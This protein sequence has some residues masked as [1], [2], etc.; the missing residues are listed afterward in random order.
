MEKSSVNL[1]Q[2]I[3]EILIWWLQLESKGESVTAKNLIRKIL[4]KLWTIGS[5]SPPIIGSL[6]RVE[7]PQIPRRF[8]DGQ[9][10]MW[11]M[12]VELAQQIFGH[13]LCAHANALD[14]NVIRTKEESL[15]SEE[16]NNDEKERKKE[17][18]REREREATLRVKFTCRSGRLAH[19]T[20]P[21]IRCES[22]SIDCLSCRL[23][24]PSPAAFYWD[25]TVVWVGFY[26]SQLRIWASPAILQ[27]LLN[28]FKVQL[29]FCRVSLGFIQFYGFI[30][31]LSKDFFS[32][33][34]VHHW[35]FK[36]F[37]QV[38]TRYFL[39]STE[40]YW[41]L[42]ISGDFFQWIWAGFL[43]KPTVYLCFTNHKTNL[44]S[45]Y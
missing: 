33:P 16:K 8:G 27:A 31:G 32:K 14:S 34:T 20:G 25:C 22:T 41:V 10:K 36:R 12:A 5:N 7:A 1:V 15:A 42:S 9:K 11:P 45:T 24:P 19:F 40:Y 29:G 21:L 2:R 23:L 6:Q 26:S 38:L 39:I 35:T 17:R 43:S 13:R 30:K 37:S 3:H 28:T 4:V 44:E 18:K